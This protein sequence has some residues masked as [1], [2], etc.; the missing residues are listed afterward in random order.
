MG[1]KWGVNGAIGSL[2]WGWGEEEQC[3][4]P[5]AG[6]YLACSRITEGPV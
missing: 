4:G 3:K 6:K 5:G 2:E 1:A